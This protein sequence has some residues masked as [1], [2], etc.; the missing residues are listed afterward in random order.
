MGEPLAID[1]HQRCDRCGHSFSFHGKTFEVTCRAMGCRG[2]EDGAR[3]PGF[4]LAP[5]DAPLSTTA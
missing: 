4:V 1:L 2:G 3:C 5:T